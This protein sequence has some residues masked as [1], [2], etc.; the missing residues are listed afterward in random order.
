[1]G[2]EAPSLAKRRA[3]K[4]AMWTVLP[5]VLLGG[6]L[7]TFHQNGLYAWIK[8]LHI[9]SVISWMAGLLYLPRLFIYHTSAEPGSVQSETF[10][11]MERRLLQL[12]MTPAMMYTWVFGLYLSWSVYGFHG[13][14]LHTKILLVI[15]MSALHAI[16]SRGLRQF[17]NDKNTHTARYWRLMNEAPTLIMIIVIVLVVVKPF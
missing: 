16:F 12:I 17:A 6:C 5:P 1:M 2:S 4:R 13:G 10:K 9:I 11:V 7:L 3:R 15:A 8:A 14:W